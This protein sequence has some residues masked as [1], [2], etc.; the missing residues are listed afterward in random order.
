[1]LGSMAASRQVW[2][3]RNSCWFISSFAAGGIKRGR[4]RKGER[5]REREREHILTLTPQ[6]PPSQQG[7]TS[8]PSQT[9][10][11]AEDQALKHTILGGRAV[12]SFK[13]PQLA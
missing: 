2:H 13:P 8:N 5:K 12:F 9:V 3:Q 1:M 7:H 4:E 10:P 6:S 11:P